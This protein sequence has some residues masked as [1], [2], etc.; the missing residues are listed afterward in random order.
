MLASYIQS[1]VEVIRECTSL[2]AE[3]NGYDE[4]CEQTRCIPRKNYKSSPLDNH[5]PFPAV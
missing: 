3:A 1:R 5:V 2:M 4:T